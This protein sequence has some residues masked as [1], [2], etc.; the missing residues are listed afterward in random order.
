MTASTWRQMIRAVLTPQ[1]P[2]ERR[3][4]AVARE[5]LP[6]PLADDPRQFLGRH[7]AGC[8]ATW[9]I[10]EACQFACSA[11]YLPA[12][13]DTTP[14]L[15]A[16]E[17]T[18]QLEALRAHLGPW[19]T[20]Q[21][22][23][24]EVTLLPVERVLDILHT[25]RRLQLTPMLMTN[26]EVLRNEPDFGHPDCTSVTPLLVVRIGTT[27]H[28]VQAQRP[29]SR[30]DRWFLARLLTGGLAGYNPIGEARRVACARLIGR[31]ARNPRLLLDIPLFAACRLWSERRIVLRLVGGL[32]TRTVVS[33]RP[34]TIVVHNF[35]AADELQ[36]P[37]GRERLRACS[38]RVALD[39]ELVSM[40]EFNA[41]ETRRTQLLALQ[42]TGTASPR[43]ATAAA[44][45][46][47]RALLLLCAALVTGCFSTLHAPPP[48]TAA[49]RTILASPATSVR[50]A[51][52]F[53]D[54]DWR[55]VLMR[56]VDER[57]R[58]D[59]AALA[60]QRSALDRF[61]ARLALSGPE[62]T[63]ES[64][65]TKQDRV[66]Y[67]LNACNA[68]VIFSDLEHP[69]LESDNDSKID[70]FYLTC[71]QLDG[72]EVNLYELENDIVRPRF[73]RP[74]VHIALNCVSISCPELPRE[75]F[76]GAL[77]D[78][79]PAARATRFLHAR[80]NVTT[81]DGALVLSEIFDWFAE[82]FVPDAPTWIAAQAPDLRLS[83]GL[84]VT[85]RPWNWGL[86]AS[87]SH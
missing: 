10:H 58:V 36:T 77:L 55:D 49:V 85:F 86:N 39:G 18:A 8:G 9:G 69:G 45:T 35:M 21:I 33:M 2:E 41:T 27:R 74:E 72:A 20:V 70:F 54:S 48:A 31:L 60:G 80:S 28:I 17:V 43:A 25:C 4:V 75:P 67:Y 46:A 42:P 40:C 78:A 32:F 52:G 76:T 83:P 14:P 22:T 26:G 79:Q 12:E 16:L 62:T 81:E 29:G 15:P 57:G 65:P 51:P 84:P 37:V 66:A 61:V 5:R 87:T 47:V 53:D 11:C 73:R 82:D 64:F 30:L 1:V 50:Q 19:G 38:F 23:A 24:G 63:P 34:L 3:A 71:F 6:S 68:L 44:N 7:T 56:F 13:A 59:D